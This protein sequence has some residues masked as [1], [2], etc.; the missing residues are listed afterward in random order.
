MDLSRFL[1]YAR[2]RRARSTERA[3]L[4]GARPTLE[5]AGGVRT[6][7]YFTNSNLSRILMP[8]LL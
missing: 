4:A 3:P 5:H 6:N 8:G 1:R 7:Q 2:L